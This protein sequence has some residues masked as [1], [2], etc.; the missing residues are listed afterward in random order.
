LNTIGQ[1][2]QG[3]KVAW[4]TDSQNVS[5]I[6]ETGSKKPYLQKIAL[7]IANKCESQQIQLN[8][9]WVPRKSNIKADLLSRC[10]DS[11]DWSVKITVFNEID[12]IWG[13]HTCD[14]FAADYNTK[15]A[16]F[17]SRWWC[18]NTTGIDAFNQYW[19][20]ENNWLVPP[21]RLISKTINKLKCD[22]AKGTL[23][24]PKWES[25][26]FWP[27]LRK[28]NDWNDWV[29]E[30]KTVNSMITERGRGQNGIFGGSKLFD[31]IILR[32]EF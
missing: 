26:P 9:I 6:L 8:A 16:Q 1:N 11:D 30:V 5:K 4:H 18:P 14:R 10:F 28:G 19:G 29:K 7:E 17:N 12:K 13:K 22:K 31:M 21:P 2:I 24:I 32:I 20:N 23:V 15:C 3:Q 27:L 25:A